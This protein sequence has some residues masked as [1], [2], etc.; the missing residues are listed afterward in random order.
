MHGEDEDVC[1]SIPCKDGQLVESVEL[2]ATSTAISELNVV[3]TPRS[4]D[5]TF[6]D[7]LLQDSSKC[8]DPETAVGASITCREQ[9]LAGQHMY[10]HIIC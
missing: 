5:S 2:T 9:P 7:A 6:V 1:V 3:V 10:L 4:L 8:F